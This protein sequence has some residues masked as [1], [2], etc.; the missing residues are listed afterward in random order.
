MT[1]KAI[2]IAKDFSEYPYGRH[3][4][5]SHTSGVRLRDDY[6]VPLLESMRKGECSLIVIELDGAQGYGSGFLEEAFGGLVRLGYPKSMLL[7]RMSIISL[8]DP[9]L[10]D[11]IKSYIR[12]ND[13]KVDAAG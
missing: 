3:K 6:I 2:N 12:E 7:D 4:K 8:Q 5:Y 1:I 13:E 11:K 9:S 10:I